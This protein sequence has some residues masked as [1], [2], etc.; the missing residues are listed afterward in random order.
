ML[1][2]A[3]GIGANIAIFTIVQ[4]VLIRPLAFAESDRLHVVTYAPIGIR[5]WLYPGLSDSHYLDFRRSATL[6]ESLATFGF[7]PMALTG[8]GDAAQVSG[9]QVTTD[10]FRVMRVNPILGRSFAADDDQPDRSRVVL[11]GHDLWT[12]KF[13][14]NVDLVNQSIVLDGVPHAVIGI[15]PA[16]F[17]YPQDAQLWTP[18]AVRLST[19]TTFTR[20]VIGRLR[21]GV[22]R[23]QAKA[24]L[25][26]FVTGLPDDAQRR[27][28]SADVIPL[29]HAVAGESR[30]SLIIFTG[31]VALVLLIACANVSNLVLMRALSRQPE[32][33]TRL[34]LGASRGR[35]VRQLLTESTLLAVAGGLA[36]ALVAVGGL[37]ALLA[38]VP[39]GRLPRLAEIHMDAWTVAFTVGLSVAIGLVVGLVPAL[40]STRGGV[41]DALRHRLET[42]GPRTRRVRHALVVAEVALAVVLV[43][44]A[45]LL[46]KSLT[47]L[48]SVP[49]GFQPEQVLTMTMNLPPARY[50]DAPGMHELYRRILAS[51]ETLPDVT[52]ATA[53]NWRP[54]GTMAI[55]G[56][57]AVEGLRRV[58]ETY[59]PMKVSV[60][61]GY[62]RTLGI[63]LATGRDFT[64]QDDEQAPGVAIVSC[65]R[66][67]IVVARR[68]SAREA[69][70]IRG[71]SAAAGLGHGDWCRRRH[72]AEQRETGCRRRRFT[73][74]TG[75]RLS[76]T[77]CDT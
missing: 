59:N 38:L 68:R 6:F 52:S 24:G 10:F 33:T 46:I 61:P 40:Q 58:S 22:T 9:A 32:I 37:P 57:I 73:G 72:P 60:S 49:L 53:V 35:I 23:A 44:G 19:N 11:V 30:E 21:P 71:E 34:A 39:A 64:A 77:F 43:I 67:A 47:R 50:A 55:R 65:V 36:G 2:L 41:V 3:L 63:R 28:W 70:G 18:L 69:A 76:R 14:A 25:E 7:S 42:A 5:Y 27:N 8:A 1:T 31:A 56:D 12:A 26:A 62:F 74:R 15:L 45:G 13:G 29:K 54:F 75:R 51:L 20:P 66:R 17:D 48:Q 4:G 16:G